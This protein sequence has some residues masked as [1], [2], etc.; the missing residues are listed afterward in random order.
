MPTR[1]IEQ[2]HVKTPKEVR[3]LLLLTYPHQKPCVTAAADICP[4]PDVDDETQRRKVRREAQIQFLR[5]E[6]KDLD[7]NRRKFSA[8][9]VNDAKKR[10]TKE[11]DADDFKKEP[12]KKAKTDADDADFA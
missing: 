5:D 12:A 1:E 4:P 3:V 6:K 9:A 7:T 10:K 2:F 11:G 8:V